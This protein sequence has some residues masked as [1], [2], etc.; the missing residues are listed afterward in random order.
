MVKKVVVELTDREY[1]ILEKLNEFEGD[2]SQKLKALFIDYL[3]QT[4]RLKANYHLIKLDEKKDYLLEILEY[5]WTEYEKNPNPLESWDSG[6]YD[7]IQQELLQI[8]VIRP[9]GAG[10]FAPTYMFKKPWLSVYNSTSKVFPDLDEFSQAYLATI[11]ML[12]Y[13]SRGTLE[14]ELLRDS[15]MIL[16]EF[17]MY[18]Y[19]VAKKTAHISKEALEERK[20][21]SVSYSDDSPA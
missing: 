21:K 12:D 11:Y 19:A 18:T 10:R 7:S 20:K 17:Y 8:N 3:A 9:M 1:L 15:T 4:P 6:K 2:C 14:K 16:N 5:I 13:L